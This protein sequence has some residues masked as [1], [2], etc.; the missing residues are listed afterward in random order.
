MRLSAK[1][2]KNFFGINQFTYGSEWS[3]REGEP[4]TLYFQ[5]VDLDQEGLRYL[6]SSGSSVVVTFPA[7]NS[8][9]ELV[10]SAV[11]ASVDDKSVWKVDLTASEKPYSGNVKVAL[12]ESG[13]TKRFNI[14]QGLIVESLDVG[15]C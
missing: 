11:Q 9:N 14:L 13:V 4:N 15:G 2:I 6:P 5:L 7:L 10:K 3:I 12:T 1:I 8:A